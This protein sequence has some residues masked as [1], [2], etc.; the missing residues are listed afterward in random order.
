MNAPV[1]VITP[2]T[3]FG[4][5]ICQVM[6]EAGGYQVSLCTTSQEAL[7]FVQENHAALAVIDA[8]I[9]DMPL[10]ELSDSLRQTIQGMLVLLIPPD[11]DE[12]DEST[13]DAVQANGFLSKPF[14]LPDLL[15][16]V[17]ETVKNNPLPEPAIE[18]APEP[19]ASQ[20][21]PP[22][23]MDGSPAP[24]WIRDVSLAAQHLTRLSLESASQA[25]LITRLEEIWAYAGELPQP[26]A[27][28]LARTVA[29]Y[30][31]D[32]GGSDLARF[33]H[34]D[35]TG[36]EYMLYATGLGGEYVLSMVFDAETP[37][38]K[39]RSQANKLASALSSNPPEDLSFDTQASEVELQADEDTKPHELAPLLD[40]V[41]PPIPDDWMPDYQNTE[42]RKGFLDELMDED[43]AEPAPRA[44]NFSQESSPSQQRESL[45]EPQAVEVEVEEPPVVEEEPEADED[46]D[47][48][49]MDDLLE[50]ILAQSV[51]EEDETEPEPKLEPE[52]DP[53]FDAA[54]YRAVDPEP[55]PELEPVVDAVAFQAVETEPETIIEETAA[56]FVE[57]PEPVLMEED[58]TIASGTGYDDMTAVSE[59]V[60]ED[61]EVMAE[62]MP[63]KS[64]QEKQ[65]AFGDAEL[66]PVSPSMYN[67]TYACVLI[68][69]MP[70]HHLTGDLAANLSE[71]VTQLCLAFGWRLEQLS[72]RPEYLQWMV[73]VPPATSPG[74][75][76]RIIRQHTS[77]RLF[78]EFPRMEDVNPSGDFW[79]P[80][81]LIMSGN[82]PPPPQLVKD[83][84]KNT[85]KRQGISK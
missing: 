25:S 48:E 40:D 18:T 29:R 57:E 42:K 49:M 10:S 77:R 3:G 32:G 80:G 58:Q 66:Q 70:A 51:R 11:N 7:S 5:L 59:S 17:E 47:Q 35:A 22:L 16:M 43:E 69:R 78:V 68:P 61:D 33:I 45:S 67:L 72:I 19:P 30:F 81:Y 13:L 41:P 38:S 79:A 14:Y 27:Q 55:V 1:I 54:A 26:A 56:P 12:I 71:W 20:A 9:Q 28:E 2:S 75:L 85:R 21:E 4:E 82:E 52:F 8:D 73:N 50:E 37:F 44:V 74:Y 84:I 6:D 36:G 83:F 34:L 63:S 60:R 24:E 23:V 53:A 39:I 64:T 46:E 15:S 31:A 65:A 76:M 62:T